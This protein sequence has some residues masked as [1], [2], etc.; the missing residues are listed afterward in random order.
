M[1]TAV[2]IA[3]AAKALNVAQETLR[4]KLV[5]GEIPGFRVGSAARPMW[6]IF[7]DDLVAW[8]QNQY[9]QKAERSAGDNAS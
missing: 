8:A 6:R 2:S 4:R 9:A 3:D 7:E 1:K 5:A